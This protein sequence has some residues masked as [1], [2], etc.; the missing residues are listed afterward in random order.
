[1]YSEIFFGGKE[2]DDRSY[3]TKINMEGLFSGRFLAIRFILWGW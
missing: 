1:M 3:I 2:Y